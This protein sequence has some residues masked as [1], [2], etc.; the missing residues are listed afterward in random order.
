MLRW[1]RFCKAGTKTILNEQKGWEWI[2][3][4]P[5]LLFWGVLCIHFVSIQIDGRCRPVMLILTSN[6]SGRKPTEEAADKHEFSSCTLLP[7]A[8]VV[9]MLKLRRVVIVHRAGRIKQ[10][11]QKVS[12][13]VA[14]LRGVVLEAVH[15]I[16]DMGA[17]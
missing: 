12:L 10:H 17:V 7:T 2:A 8:A 9:I 3:S 1:K 11:G 6:R 4:L 14:Y 15:D 16:L 5:A 13:D